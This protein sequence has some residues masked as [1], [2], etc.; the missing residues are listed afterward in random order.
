MEDSCGVL[1]VSSFTHYVLCVSHDRPDGVHPFKA[2][3][4]GH[5][6]YLL[7]Q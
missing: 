6:N 2:T 7:L 3:A 4:I 1:A 5:G